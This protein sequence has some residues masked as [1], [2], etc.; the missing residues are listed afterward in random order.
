MPFR[1]QDYGV[2]SEACCSACWE[3]YWCEYSISDKEIV[4]DKLYINAKNEHYS[5]INGISPMN[6]Q[7]NKKLRYMGN[8]LYQY[9]NIKIPY[10]GRIMLGKDFMREYYIHMGYQRAWAY[11]VLTEFI[12]ENGI[13]FETIDH[14][15][16]AEKLRR[17]IDENS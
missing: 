17:Q 9:I 5:Q 10:T 13:L 6:E 8:N 16:M 1:P 2:T 14:S 3:G 7:A 12:F 15:G 4:L 11:K